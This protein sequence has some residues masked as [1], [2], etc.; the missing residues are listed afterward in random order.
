MQF[1]ATRKWNKKKT[2]EEMKTNGRKKKIESKQVSIQIVQHAG[3]LAGWLDD[4]LT[5]NSF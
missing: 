4:W 2:E 5:S 3:W 1:A